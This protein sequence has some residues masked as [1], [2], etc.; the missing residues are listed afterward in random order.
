MTSVAGTV[1]RWD[2]W[3]ASL[4]PM[5]PSCLLTTKVNIFIS[6]FH[7]HSATWALT[8]EVALR[9]GVRVKCITSVHAALRRCGEIINNPADTHSE[10][11]FVILLLVS[12]LYFSSNDVGSQSSVLM[13]CWLLG[14]GNWKIK[15]SFSF[16]KVAK[17]EL[18][19]SIFKFTDQQS[20][21]VVFRYLLG[22]VPRS[23]RVNYVWLDVSLHGS[24]GLIFCWH[25]EGSRSHPAGWSKENKIRWMIERYRCNWDGINI[26]F[27]TF[28][29]QTMKTRQAVQVKRTFVDSLTTCRT[30][31][32]YKM[33]VYVSV[34]S[35]MPLYYIF[36]MHI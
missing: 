15:R 14:L 5:S 33:L 2:G 36:L 4:V 35:V 26:C 32:S 22:P 27:W 19:S 18:S 16:F 34:E 8:R 21:H 20:D 24:H 11:I 7:S 29:R 1:P 17:L 25:S 28:G 10:T 9:D 31:D 6:P 12:Q 13:P 23:H 3:S 30:L